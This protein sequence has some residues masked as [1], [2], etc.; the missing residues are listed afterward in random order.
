MAGGAG[1]GVFDAGDEIVAIAGLAVVG[2]VFGPQGFEMPLDGVSAIWAVELSLMQ[3]EPDFKTGVRAGDAHAV[4]LAHPD[5]R[6]MIWVFVAIKDRP[7]LILRLEGVSAPSFHLSA[8]PLRN[9]HGDAHRHDLQCDQ[10]L[11][12]VF[13]FKRTKIIRLRV[14]ALAED[15]DPPQRLPLRRA[16]AQTVASSHPLN[17]FL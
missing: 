2:V 6:L 14:F 11:S 16:A 7:N 17:P 12:F 15:D 5:R 3:D 1:F 10:R 13:P 4:L 8:R 9:G